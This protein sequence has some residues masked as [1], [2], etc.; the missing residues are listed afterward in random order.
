MQSLTT[1]LPGYGMIYKFFN[2]NGLQLPTSTPIGILWAFHGR[3]R[4]S[5]GLSALKIG[6]EARDAQGDAS[7]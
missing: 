3:L 6:V 1:L 2:A 5:L 7:T 4:P